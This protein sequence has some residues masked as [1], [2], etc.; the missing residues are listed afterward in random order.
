[1]SE[2][3]KSQ[4]EEKVKDF[5]EIEFEKQTKPRGEYFETKEEPTTDSV[6]ERSIKLV[7]ADIK[8]ANIQKEKEE[9][10]NNILNEIDLKLRKINNDIV[11][12]QLI[13]SKY[14]T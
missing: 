4:K 10:V 5:F 12:T 7:V 6:Q 3:E 14:Q 2:Q 1:M 8:V 13:N 9:R 11:E